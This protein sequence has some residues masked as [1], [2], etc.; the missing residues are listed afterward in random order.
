MHACVS[1]MRVACDIWRVIVPEPCAFACC[2]RFY[3]HHYEQYMEAGYFE[4]AAEVV[5]ASIEQ[6]S[7][8]DAVTQPPP[9]TRRKPRGLT[10]L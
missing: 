1:D 3:T 6:Y 2:S 8:V 9:I 10:F 7:A 5:A 4:A